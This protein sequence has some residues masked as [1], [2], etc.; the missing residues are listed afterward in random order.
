MRERDWQTMAAKVFLA[1]TFL[2][3]A[4]LFFEYVF[5]AVLPL[6]AALFISWM[7]WRVSG[8]IH[9]ATGIPRGFCSFALVTLM[10]LIIGG[11]TVLAFRQLLAEAT[12]LL[13][14]L[15]QGDGGIWQS[16]YRLEDIPAVYPVIKYSEELADQVTPFI[17]R[18]L[19]MLTAYLG[20]ALGSI[21]KATP[22]AFLGGVVT[23]LFIYYA[24]MDLGRIGEALRGF[25]PADIRSRA[26]DMR[27]RI[28]RAVGRYL[29]AY[30]VIFALTF[31]EI[32]AGLLILCPQYCF[33]G[34]LGI[35]LIDVLPVL[36]AGLV[37]IPWGLICLLTGNV[38]RGVGLIVLYLAV[39]V[40]RQTVE[41]KIIGGSLGIHPL[42]TLT[43]IFVGYRLF[44]VGGMILAPII[45]C[46]IK[47]IR[48]VK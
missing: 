21:I 15:S 11:A 17:S 39:T 34:A 20:T 5:P 7:V 13:S 16:L 36:G 41:P 28:V 12:R 8:R 22:D 25:M 43:G 31:F 35:A 26:E 1:G 3:G 14:G 47:E 24:S 42:L 10:L 6:I 2:V 4:Y 23:V 32:L 18:G 33:I 29:R 40:I 19:E 9:K 44:G 30:A 48:G 45:I 38:F 27:K 46:V 37:L